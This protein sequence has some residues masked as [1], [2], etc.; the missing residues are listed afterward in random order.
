MSF[1]TKS[2]LTDGLFWD[3]MGIVTTNFNGTTGSMAGYVDYE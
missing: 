1:L 3:S 2:Y